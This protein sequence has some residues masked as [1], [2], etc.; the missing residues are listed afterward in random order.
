MITEEAKVTPL[1]ARKFCVRN[2]YANS[3]IQCDAW[4]HRCDGV[5]QTPESLQGHQFTVLGETV[6]WQ[7][8]KVYPKL[9]PLCRQ[10]G[11]R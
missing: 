7:S 6:T 9:C 10:E 5:V 8:Q 11:Y 4:L 1:P 3:E 2:T